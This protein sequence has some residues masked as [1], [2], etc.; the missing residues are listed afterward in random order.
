[1]VGEMRQMSGGDGHFLRPTRL[2]GPGN[3][4]DTDRQA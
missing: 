1:M 4:T 3:D 2:L